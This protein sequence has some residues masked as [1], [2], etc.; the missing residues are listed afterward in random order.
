MLND[1]TATHALSRAN[2]VVGLVFDPAAP[3]AEA[4]VA[5]TFGAGALAYR[6]V[7]RRLKAP[8][9]VMVGRLGRTPARTVGARDSKRLEEALVAGF[10]MARELAGHST[11]VISVAEPLRARAVAVLARLDE[12]PGGIQ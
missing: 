12:T 6:E 1:F 5:A 8:V 10:E 4:G 11:W 7:F 9:C 3:E 2:S